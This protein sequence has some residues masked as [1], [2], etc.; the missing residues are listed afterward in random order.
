MIELKYFVIGLIQGLTEFLPISSSGHLV[1]LSKITQWEDQGLITDIAVHVGTLLAVIIYLRKEIFFLL[2]KLIQFNL[3]E[4]NIIFKITLSTIPAIIVGYFIYD[5]VNLYFRNL[6]LVAISSIV[7]AIIL[8]ISDRNY[9]NQKEWKGITYKEAFIIGLFQIFAF[10]PGA[11]RAGV[12][13]TGARFLGYN[14]TDSAIFSMLL[15]IPIILA[16]L[17]LS[18][19]ELIN[20]GHNDINLQKPIFAAFIAFITAILSINFMMKLIQSTN[21]NLFIIYRIL[22]GILLLFFYG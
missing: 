20:S 4:S 14:R 1:L 13:I 3:I 19:F 7:F 12:T 11:S 17:T 21:F 10:I 6:Q 18:Y 22:L 9:E 16:S 5:F 2:K 8:Y 15:S